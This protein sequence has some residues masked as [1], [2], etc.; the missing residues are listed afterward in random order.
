MV[1]QPFLLP[2]IGNDLFLPNSKSEFV[3][4]RLL[5]CALGQLFVHF[6]P[7]ELLSILRVKPVFLSPLSHPQSLSEDRCMGCI[8]GEKRRAGKE[9]T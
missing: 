2:E 8:H 9:G 1:P 4:H 5:P 3:L 7:T 6:F